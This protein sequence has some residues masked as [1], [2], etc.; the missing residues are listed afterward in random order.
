MRILA[1]LLVAVS[2]Y[3]C[4]PARR[5]GLPDAIRSTEKKF[6]DH[7]GFSLYDLVKE[8][9]V[10]E[11][12]ADKYFTPASNTKI[13][14][15][16]TALRILGDSVPALKYITRNDSMIVWGTG[17]PTFLYK[18]AFDNGRVYRFLRT[19]KPPLYFSS[20]NFFTTH[21]GAGWA[22]D[23][24]N[25]TYSSERSPLPVYGNLFTV[26]KSGSLFS[27]EP[28]HFETGFSIGERRKRA[29][30]IR[31]VNSNNVKYHPGLTKPKEKDSWDVPMRLSDSLLLKLLADT[32]KRP[33]HHCQA[34]LPPLALDFYS[35]P[36]DSLYRVMMQ[37]SDNFIAEQ[38]LLV[39]SQVVRDSMKTEIAINYSIENFLDDLPDKPVWVDGSGLSRYNLFTPRSIVKLWHKIYNQV[40]RE[41][42]FSLLATGGKS[43]TVRNWYKA[44]R[45]FLFGKT[46]TLS[47]NHSL[48]G[49]LVTK[50]GKTLIFCFMNSN[51][52]VST[53]EI[54]TNMQN[55]LKTIY[56]KY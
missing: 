1:V 30:L 14:T 21:F 34:K 47:N 44:D 2:L 18:Y 26:Q 43:G 38:L 50:S 29:E 24:Y 5:L 36:A 41:R 53:S 54:R 23:D 48:S 55:I 4:S 56:E 7:V 25:S 17:D 13:F 3:S 28:S 6:Q 8:R 51:Y 27:A 46:G 12:N 15:F 22:W 33:V 20:A 45:P 39:C 19:V 40:D 42:L 10:F 52:V 11:Y 32:L 31:D 35:V 9:T 16:Y 49:Y 37:D